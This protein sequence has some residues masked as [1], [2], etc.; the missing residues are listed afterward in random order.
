MKKILLIAPSWVG[1]AIMSQ[2]L[3]TE[4][5][6]SNKQCQLDVLAPAWVSPVFKTM[7]A[8][9][10]TLVSPFKHGQLK[11]KE[12][13]KLGAYIRASSYDECYVL[14]NSFKSALIP[15]FARIPVRVGYIGECRY[16]LLTKC[17]PLDKK[18][19]PM[20]VDRFANLAD[21]KNTNIDG[22][23]KWP[24]LTIS[25]NSKALIR[26]KFFDETT[27]K[28]AC[29]CPGAEFGPSKIWPQKKYGQ[30]AKRLT[31]QGYLVVTIGS[32]N[33][34]HIGKKISSESGNLVINLC[35]Q[36]TLQEAIEVIGTSDLV[37]SN[38]SGLMHVA[39]ALDRPLIA[40]FGSSSPE[41]TPP[42]TESALISR[43]ELPCS[44]CFERSC[45]LNHLKCLN[46][47]SVQSVENQIDQ[48][49]KQLSEKAIRPKSGNLKSARS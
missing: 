27:K 21:H 29:F 46:N 15:F 11:L 40:I 37:I 8:V 38:D 12:R 48:L 19:Y 10:K 2:P 33:D 39:A 41:F 4:L 6:N 17:L 35:G 16:P 43:I 32:K 23:P 5:K 47:I 3:I 34:S 7:E 20:M 45:P 42:L 9:E 18:K 26:H 22:K 31:K 49:L 24:K 14:P 28:I 44:P 36:T 25:K 1:D 30:L 13:I